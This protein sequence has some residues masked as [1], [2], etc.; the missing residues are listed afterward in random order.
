MSIDDKIGG[1]VVGPNSD[2]SLSTVRGD[3]ISPLHVINPEDGQ[4]FF[5]DQIHSFLRVVLH[6]KWRIA[7]F[8]IVF[9]G[10]SVIISFTKTPIYKAT[11]TI[12]IGGEIIQLTDSESP[13]SRATVETQTV[14]TNVQL[15]TSRSVATR[16]VN[17]LGL[18][19]EFE[20]EYAETPP[21]LI[22]RLKSFISSLGGNAEEKKEVPLSAKIR[23]AV[24]RVIS[25]TEAGPV[26]G[27]RILQITYADKDPDRARRI[28]DTIADE[29]IRSNIDR[30]IA[31]S[32]YASSI[33]EEQLRL[34]KIRLQEAERRAI[35]YASEQHLTNLDNKQSLISNMLESLNNALSAAMVDR[36]KAE[37]IWNAIKDID[38]Q[39]AINIPS[40]SERFPLL[41]TLELQKSQIE[42]EYRDKLAIFKPAYPTMVAMKERLSDIDNQ[43]ADQ[44]KDVKKV[45]RAEYEIALSKESGMQQQISVA[46]DQIINARN[47]GIEYSF[48]QREA[49]ANRS[50]YEG[51]LQRYREITS[52][53]SVAN[54]SMSIVDK[55]TIPFVPFSPRKTLN[56]LIGIIL[57][58]FVGI[59]YAFIREQMDSSIKTPEQIERRL[60]MSM[61]GII[62]RVPEGGPRDIREILEERHS[63]ITEEFRSV[64]TALQFSTSSG[65]PSTLMVTSTV[66][67]EGKSTCSFA[68]ACMFAQIGVKVVL[69]DADLRKPSI[70]RIVQEDN[71]TGL[72]NYLSGSV[73]KS[74]IYKE[75]ATKNLSYIVAGPQPPNPAELLSG[76]R[77][78][79]LVAELRQSH[80]LIIIDTPP[81]LGIADSRIISS[82]VEGCLIVCKA[83]STH[84]K[85]IHD[86]VKQLQSAHAN[87]I[88]IILNQYDG[89]KHGYGYGY[90]YDYG[91]GYGYGQLQNR[92]EGEAA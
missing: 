84:E 85:S 60:H 38:D 21:S 27:S 24:D 48:L 65:V 34:A 33:L 64:R 22:A 57:G 8:I 62:S 51:I 16:V 66:P 88:G 1:S 54:N 92:D 19:E 2:N 91:Y 63:R 25:S 55:A 32:S 70:H 87:I 43:I 18:V 17:K 75:S 79:E 53:G 77:L 72:S 40:I 10:I 7:F 12:D 61:L 4:S 28:A 11:A 23:S 20:K 9:F 39:S 29:F 82:L 44:L 56:G 71:S 73:S 35:D 26:K 37:N 31:A 59:A 52:V 78:R 74:D 90:G 81:V 50:I 30:Q 58:L 3:L 36:V 67:A 15:L 13:Q 89:K 5:G 68:I 14:Q 6:N 47:R 46:T 80:D 41:K 42:T 76:A 49:D 45:V 69:I 83:G 86:A